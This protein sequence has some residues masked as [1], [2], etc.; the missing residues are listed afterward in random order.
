MTRGHP[1]RR[2]PLR[3]EDACRGNARP[4]NGADSGVEAG[5]AC[6]DHPSA[7]SA[8]VRA[9]SGAAGR[10]RRREQCRRH[11]GL[12]ARRF[13]Q[14]G[15]PRGLG[16]HQHRVRHRVGVPRP[17]RQRPETAVG[18]SS[19]RTRCLPIRA[20]GQPAARPLGL[21]AQHPAGVPRRARGRPA[22]AAPADPTDPRRRA[23]TRRPG[24]PAR[25]AD[26]HAKPPRRGSSS[27]CPVGS[28]PRSPFRACDS[29]AACTSFAR[30]RCAS[31][32]PRQ[33]PCSRDAASGSR[34]GRSTHCT[35][36]PAVGSP[37]CGWPR[38]R[39]PGPPTARPSSTG[40][41][42]TRAQS[43]TTWS[44]RSCRRCRRTSGSS[45]E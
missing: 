24:G 7:T 37:A 6:Q 11:V 8:R 16:T 10:P 17:R 36:A 15:A 34:R 40:S 26:S 25:P 43:R 28:I 32:R 39:P 22:G 33:R 41:P 29:R 20:T 35:S 2:D 45:C 9:A 31:R 4:G 42:A 21:A 27:S 3:H 13:R 1:C 18:V 38:W 12:R 44:A 14:D 19:G 5:S 23:R 30:S